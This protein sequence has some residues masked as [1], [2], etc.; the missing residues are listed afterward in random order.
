MR[1]GRIKGAGRGSAGSDGRPRS[2]RTRRGEAALDRGAV[3]DRMG[4][5]GDLQCNLAVQAPHCGDEVSLR[6]ILPE[7]I[8]LLLLFALGRNDEDVEDDENEDPGNQEGSAAVAHMPIGFTQSFFESTPWPQFIE[9]VDDGAIPT[10]QFR[11][12]IPARQFRVKR[13]AARFSLDDRKI[14]RPPLAPRVSFPGGAIGLPL[15]A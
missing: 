12:A 13:R 10:L 11:Q 7:I 15:G 14:F 4:F 5:V 9:T 8:L 6:Q 1:R 3:E 2:V